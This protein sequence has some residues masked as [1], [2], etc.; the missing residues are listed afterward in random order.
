M[1]YNFSKKIIK[2]IESLLGIKVVKAR[3]P[4]QGM[5]SKVIFV[6]DERN[7]EYAVKYGKNSVSDASAYTILRDNKIDIPVPKVFG[8][9]EFSGD[10]V[11]ILE[12]IKFPLLET[13]SAN[14]M[15]KYIPSMIANLKKIHEVKSDK[16]GALFENEGT[17][18]WQE[19][20]LSKFNGEDENLNWQ[21]ITKRDSLDGNLIL[22]A[23][24]KVIKKIKSFEFINQSY[25]LLHT[26]FNQ[27]NLFVNPKTDDI[28]G[29]IDWGEAMFG[30]PIYDFARIRMY[31]WHFNLQDDVLK[32]YY[33]L[34]SFTPY[35]KKLEEFYWVIRIIEYLA[36]YSEE[37]NEFNSGR[38]KLHQDFL[39]NYNWNS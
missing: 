15:Y 38:I 31:I 13:I 11:L 24:A 18:N 9:F 25:S 30:D 29:I 4:P 21:K 3:V 34:L 10:A 28:T 2:K 5:D 37:M 23:V 27:R 35:E 19:I 14:K 22:Q 20:M 7:M 8:I 16:A 33:S 26:D 32:K 6:V 39:R 36:Y 17:N 12:R 1:D